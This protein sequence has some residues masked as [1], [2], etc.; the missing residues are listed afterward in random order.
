MKSDIIRR[1]KLSQEVQERLEA[2]ICS[3]RFA[4]GTSLPSERELM[5]RFGVGRPS[6]R[7]A[8]FSLQ[9]MGMVQVNGGEPTRVTEPRAEA[10]VRELSGAV[11]LLIGDPV[12]MRALQDARTLFETALARRMAQVASEGDLA[13]L[14]AALDA[15]RRAMGDPQEFNR[16]DLAFHFAIATS[17]ANSIVV[18]LHEAVAEWLTEQRTES[19]K[20]VG[21]ERRAFEAH[22]RIYDAIR[23]Q[24]PDLAEREMRGHLEDISRYY[25]QSKS[26]A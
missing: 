18:A 4:P 11:R 19:L 6:I 26:N 23:R 20:L 2:D 17:S 24:D 14:E 7:E 25:W 9:K 13:R 12:H 1:R 3:G 22:S 10:L 16:T 21:V 8:L 15:N 5:K